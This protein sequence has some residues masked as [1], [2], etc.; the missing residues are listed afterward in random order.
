MSLKL[1]LSQ[2]KKAKKRKKKYLLKL[3]E[4]HCHLSTT[5]PLLILQPLLYHLLHLLLRQLHLFLLLLNFLLHTSCFRCICLKCINS[6]YVSLSFDARATF[7]SLLL[8]APKTDEGVGPNPRPP[9]QEKRESMTL[10]K[11][12]EKYKMTLL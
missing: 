7:V 10:F 11:C 1:P 5:L 2:T 3:E 4:R 12:Q 6:S 9:L 8:V